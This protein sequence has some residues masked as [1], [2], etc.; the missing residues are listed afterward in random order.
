MLRHIFIGWCVI[1]LLFFTGCSKPD[2]RLNQVQIVGTHNSYHLRPSKE[3]LASSRGRNLDYGHAPLRVQLEAGVRSLAIDI[4]QTIDAF[5]VLHIPG[6]D[7]GSNCETL[8]ECLGEITTWSDHHPDHIPLIIFIEVKNLKQPTGDLIPTDIQGMDRLETL[9]WKQLGDKKLLTPD[10]VR[11]DESTVEEAILNNGWP[12]LDSVR[13]KF[14]IVLN[15]PELLQSYYTDVS[16]T[17][18]GRAMFVKVD[19]GRPE[20]AVVVSNDP[21]AE[22]AKDWIRRGYI[23]RTRVDTGV[24]EAAENDVTIRDAAFENGSHII[25][26]DFP[27]PT[28]HPKT[29][30]VVALPDGKSWRPNPITSEEGTN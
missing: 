20:A 11:G 2:L 15:A 6:I 26:T 27:S 24:K 14:L 22:Q 12:L 7:E 16:P 13:G 5:R 25:T 9:L 23:V 3:V 30:Y 19:P 10:E 29:G 8:T 18:K 4:Y 21:T 1:Q 28:P 17:L